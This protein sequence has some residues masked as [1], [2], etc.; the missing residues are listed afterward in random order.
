MLRTI[1]FD[2]W[3]TLIY[4]TDPVA[5]FRHRAEKVQQ[6][7]K[8]LGQELPLALLT[9]EMKEIWEYT[10]RQQYDRGMDFPPHAQVRKLVENHNLKSDPDSFKEVYRAYTEALLDDPPQVVEG[11][12]EVLEELGRSFKLGLICN[13][14]STPGSVIRT[15]FKSFGLFDSFDN[16]VFSN[17]TGVAK[18]NT[19]IFKT[20]L[21][22]LETEAENALH[23]GDDPITDVTGAHRAG[24]KTIWFDQRGSSLSP[25]YDWRVSSLLEIPALLQGAAR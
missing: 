14:G 13:T 24:M 12:V 10:L 3:N 4:L 17:E 8:R 18:P 23:V 5:T 1:T 25:P 21:K 6:A 16:L 20:A 11:A 15:L 2:C 22:N 19:E 9:A 7:L